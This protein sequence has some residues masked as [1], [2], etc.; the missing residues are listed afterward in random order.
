MIAQELDKCENVISSVKASLVTL[1]SKPK[2]YSTDHL[3]SFQERLS[4]RLS[5]VRIDDCEASDLGE[6]MEILDISH[7]SSFE[8]WLFG[9]E[10]YL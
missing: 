5:L 1:S 2:R 6:L 3:S 8:D 9:I 7:P 10:R 4:Q